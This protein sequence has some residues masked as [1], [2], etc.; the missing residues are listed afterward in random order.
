GLCSPAWLARQ[1][2]ELRRAAEEAP[3]DGDAFLHLDV[4]SDN[5]CLKD[6]RALLV[7][8]NHACL[9]NPLIDLAAWLPSLHAEGGPEPWDL[10]SGQAALAAWIAGFFAARAGL[11][12]P[13]TAD[14]SLTAL[15]LPQ[16]EVALPWAARELGLTPLD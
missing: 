11:P 12:P 8:W 15:Q 14:R 9:A 5:I 3:C 7:D 13:E 1:L 6:G 2:P 4:R 16:L 10:L